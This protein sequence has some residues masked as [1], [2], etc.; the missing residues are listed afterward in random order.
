MR[1]QREGGQPQTKE[2]GLKRNQTCW[3]LFFQFFF[4][5]LEFYFIYI[6]IQQ[7]LISYP[8]YTYYCTYVN[9]N[10]PIHPTTTIPHHFPP[11]VS[12][13]LFSTSVSLLLPKPDDILILDFQPPKR[14]ENK[15]L[16]FKPPK[17]WL[18]I[19]AALTDKYKWYQSTDCHNLTLIFKW[20]LQLIWEE[21]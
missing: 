18:F 11:L 15:L 20:S 13:H 4:G 1:T 5:T 16:V 2:R 14:W 10:L 8:F 3:H 17:L 6:F 7:V 12:I 21:D 9:P 19:M